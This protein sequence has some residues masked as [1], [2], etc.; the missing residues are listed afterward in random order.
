MSVTIPRNLETLS[1]EQIAKFESDLVRI[2]ERKYQE[3]K[4]ELA[5]MASAFAQRASG[6]AAKHGV[7]AADVPVVVMPSS[8]GNG[9]HKVKTAKTRKAKHAI[10]VKYRD[11]A[12]PQNVWSGRGRPA[13]WLATMEKAGRKRDEFR[14]GR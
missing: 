9:A 8:N 2:R 4:T 1:L 5:G 14:V 3:L 12:N 10:P 7:K 6:F 13:R 11:P